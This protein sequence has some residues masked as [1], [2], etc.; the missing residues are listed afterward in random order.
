MLR[1]FAGEV[2]ALLELVMASRAPKTSLQT[3]ARVRVV[4]SNTHDVRRLSGSAGVTEM[5]RPMQKFV[6]GGTLTVALQ[7]AISVRTSGE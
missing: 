5:K 6:W 3:V 2:L 7:P 4:A 1:S